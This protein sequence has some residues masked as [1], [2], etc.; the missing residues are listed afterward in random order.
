MPVRAARAT[1]AD[2]VIAVNVDEKLQTIDA[3]QFKQAGQLTNRLVAILLEE[4]DA[5]QME[6]SDVQ[7]RPETASISIYSRKDSDIDNRQ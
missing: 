4:I 5:H 7:I 6:C 1:G 3:S 2:L